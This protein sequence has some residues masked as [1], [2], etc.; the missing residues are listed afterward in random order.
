MR[1]A[2]EA[3]VRRHVQ[4]AILHATVEGKRLYDDI[5]WQVSNEMA[6]RIAP[7]PD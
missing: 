1:L 2:E 3:F 5:G 7:L 4:F 6:K